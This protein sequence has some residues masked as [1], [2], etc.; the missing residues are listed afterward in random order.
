MIIKE[1]LDDLG[2]IVN[3]PSILWMRIAKE[4]TFFGGTM[5]R[6][7]LGVREV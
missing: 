7:L 1:G 6:A 5:A 2:C 3:S 4:P